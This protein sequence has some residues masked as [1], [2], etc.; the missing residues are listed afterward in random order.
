[1]HAPVVNGEEAPELVNN[2]GI[3]E[4]NGP[5]RY[6][7]LNTALGNK[8]LDYCRD[9]GITLEPDFIARLKAHHAL[10]E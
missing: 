5:V 2:S 4:L 8:V 6:F 7:H 3:L 10:E 9:A 1:V